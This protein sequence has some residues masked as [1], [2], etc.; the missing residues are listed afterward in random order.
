[1]PAVTRNIPMQQDKVD[2]SENIE[3]I[4]IRKTTVDPTT[5]MEEVKMKSSSDEVLCKLIPLRLMT[6][7]AL[8][9]TA[10]TCPPGPD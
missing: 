4:S 2:E 8:A 1:M 6:I 3:N 5:K 7:T 9:S 10:M